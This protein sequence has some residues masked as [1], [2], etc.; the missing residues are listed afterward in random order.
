MV[1][2]L[3]GKVLVKTEDGSLIAVGH[4][5]GGSRRTAG[6]SGGESYDHST[7]TQLEWKGTFAGTDRE[8]R[9]KK[10]RLNALRWHLMQAAHLGPH[11]GAE[12]WSRDD[13]LLMLSVLSA[14]LAE[15][16]P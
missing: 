13:A 14:L 4:L 10:Q 8:S 1:S 9:T 16:K 6:I 12:E 2:N 15:R 3:C 5:I 11:T 7:D